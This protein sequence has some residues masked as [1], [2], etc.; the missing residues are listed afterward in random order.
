M[1][2]L[3][4]TFNYNCYDHYKQKH[5]LV[6]NTSQIHFIS[7][8][9]KSTLKTNVPFSIS[10][11]I[12]ICTRTIFKGNTEV[13]NQL[14]KL[15]DVNL[16]L[17]SEYYYSSVFRPLILTT[18]QVFIFKSYDFINRTI[19]AFLTEMILANTI[20]ANWNLWWQHN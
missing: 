3:F 9:K 5:K 18:F 7:E 11:N 20:I 12:N 14:A 19:F 10:F 1:K 2:C 6:Q 15:I 8:P 17:L 16:T 4:N 13:Q